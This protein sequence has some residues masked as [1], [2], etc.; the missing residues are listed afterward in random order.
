MSGCRLFLV[1]YE[2]VSDLKKLSSLDSVLEWLFDAL[3]GYGLLLCCTMAYLV[4]IFVIWHLGLGRA[5][6]ALRKLKNDWFLLAAD[7][8]TAIGWSLTGLVTMNFIAIFTGFEHST[9]PVDWS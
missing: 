4:Y 7:F 9:V 8:I 3:Y 2:Y 1:G 6:K 5:Q